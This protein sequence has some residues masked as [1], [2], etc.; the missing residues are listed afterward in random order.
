VASSTAG[1]VPAAAAEPAPTPSPVRRGAL[2]DV[3]DP[4]LTRPVSVTQTRPRYPPFALQR[5]LAGSVSLRALVDE[6]GA[7]VEVS[8]IRASPPGQGFEDAAI[9]HVRTRVY[10][11]ATKQGVPVRVWLP[12]TIEFRAPDR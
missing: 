9:R 1:P 10:Q 11:P 7:V 4:G 12:I 8:L 3:N 2:V 6:T 5:R